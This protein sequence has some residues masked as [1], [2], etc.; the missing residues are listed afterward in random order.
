MGEDRGWGETVA[1]QSKINGRNVIFEI[2]LICKE[3]ASHAAIISVESIHNRVI[4]I[5]FIKAVLD[6]KL[7]FLLNKMFCLYAKSA[8]CLLKNEQL[9][10]QNW[11]CVSGIQQKFYRSL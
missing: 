4:D 10:V 5:F 8:F 11:K 9:N 3:K 6:G 2:L 7:D 1:R